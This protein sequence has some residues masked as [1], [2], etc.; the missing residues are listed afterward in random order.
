LTNAITIKHSFECGSSP[1]HIYLI[2]K[3]LKELRLTHSREGRSLAAVKPLN[4][5]PI[6]RSKA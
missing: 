5:D 6:S 3:I 1:A 4:L 2:T